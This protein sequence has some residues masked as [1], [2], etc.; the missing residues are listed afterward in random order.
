MSLSD[1][2][3]RG[4]ILQMIPAPY[5]YLVGTAQQSVHPTLGILRR[6]QA[7]SYASAFFWLDYNP[8]PRAGNP[9]RWAALF[10]NGERNSK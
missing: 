9:N 3:S 7:V 5:Q 1:P 2:F 4:S 8:R 10:S 6:F